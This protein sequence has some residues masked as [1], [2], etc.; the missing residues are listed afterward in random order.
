MQFARQEGARLVLVAVRELD[1]VRSVHGHRVDVE[2]LEGFEDRLPRPP[3]ERDSLLHLRR[4]RPV[5]EQHDVREGMARA[6]DRHA[7]AAGGGDLVGEVVDL[8][9]RLLEVLLVDLVR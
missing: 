3:V 2:P 1:A 8:D 5:L 9:D 7:A 6:G 4:L